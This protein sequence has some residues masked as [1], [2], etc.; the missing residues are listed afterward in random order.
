MLGGDV[1]RWHRDG[2]MGQT[3]DD[4]L[5]P[6][7]V[8]SCTVSNALDVYAVFRRLLRLPAFVTHR[9]K[10]RPSSQANVVP[11][12]VTAANALR[13]PVLPV[14]IASW[15][16]ILLGW[17]LQ[18]DLGSLTCLPAEGI[19]SSSGPMP[20]RTSWWRVKL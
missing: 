16:P 17:L 14:T 11:R 10:A 12:K 9:W 8:K 18:L 19:V 4:R 20:S 13:H 6:R 15:W 5:C 7:I 3:G 1:R 2:A